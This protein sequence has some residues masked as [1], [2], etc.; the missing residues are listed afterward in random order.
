MSL[1]EYERAME[2]YGEIIA[3]K[4][5][6]VGYDLRFNNSSGNIEL[7]HELYQKYLKPEFTLSAENEEPEYYKAY[8][9]RKNI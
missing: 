9:L 5:D 6:E 1:S 7:F 3:S 4:Q 2:E 8:F